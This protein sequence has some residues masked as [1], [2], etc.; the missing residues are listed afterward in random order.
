M[1]KN[2]RVYHQ[3]EGKKKKTFRPLN[4]CCNF[5]TVW[6]QF[7]A[8]WKFET[9]FM[10]SSYFSIN[11]ISSTELFVDARYLRHETHAKM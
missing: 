2:S 8:C 5:E 9:N 1:E 4:R 3:E 6:L 7:A 10:C 11:L